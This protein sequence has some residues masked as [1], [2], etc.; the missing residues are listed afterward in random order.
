MVDGDSASLAETCAI[1][2]SL[3]GLPLRQDIAVTGSVNQKG[4][5]QPVGG[6]NDKVDGFHDVCSVGGFTGNQGVIVPARNVVQLMLREDVVQSVK[7][8]KFRVYEVNSIDE[9]I[10]VLTGVAAG[11]PGADGTYPEGT[12]HYLVSKKLDFDDLAGFVGGAP[13]TFLEALPFLGIG[14]HQGRRH[15]ELRQTDPG[16][17][18]P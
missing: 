16:R 2:S 9:A 1:L 13:D 14:V 4:E 17:R 11:A 10:E 18:M 5:V 12:V 8:G 7:D 6:V 15:V 3:A